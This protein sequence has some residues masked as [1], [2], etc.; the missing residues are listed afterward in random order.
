MN[1]DILL[2]IL[3]Y[4]GAGIVATVILSIIVE[5]VNIIINHLDGKRWVSQVPY[6][7]LVGETIR[8]TNNIL[9]E[10]KITQ[11]PSFTIRYYRHKK[12]AGVFNGQVVVYLK[13]NRDIP[14][15]VNTVLHEVMHYIQSKTDKQYKRYGEYTTTFGYWNN[16]LEKEARDFADKYCEQC[17]IYLE[18]KKLIKKQ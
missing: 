17:L 15:L 16:P 7:K 5:V 12:F 13:S 4:T 2:K 3:I 8:Y 6:T 14:V 9:Y 10:K 18:S 11:F 1:I